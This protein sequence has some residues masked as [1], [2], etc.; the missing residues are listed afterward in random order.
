MMQIQ[1]ASAAKASKLRRIRSLSERTRGHKIRPDT[2][3]NFR[4]IDDWNVNVLGE[5]D[6]EGEIDD[7][8]TTITGVVA[9]FAKEIIIDLPWLTREGGCWRR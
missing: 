3:C 7:K 8:W 9:D 4:V 5:V 6:L 2:T 1:K